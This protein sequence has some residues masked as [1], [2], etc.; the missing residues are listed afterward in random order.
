MLRRCI[1]QNLIDS[2][3][4]N[5]L[6]LALYQA[7]TE[8]SR[9]PDAFHQSRSTLGQRIQSTANMVPFG[10]S[11]GDFA[12]A[13]GL[14]VKISKAL[15]DSGTAAAE[16]RDIIQDLQTLQ[17]LLE[18][19]ETLRPADGSV[20]HINAIRGMALACRTPLLEFAE[21]IESYEPALCVGSSKGMFT[22]GVKKVQWAVLVEEGIAKFRGIIAAK[23][24]IITLLL[25]AFNRYDSYPGLQRK[26]SFCSVMHCQGWKVS[27]VTIRK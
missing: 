5:L 12:T 15:K 24:Q 8:S 17:Q 7:T 9:S 23:V 19:L 16:C 14:I 11:A 25:E 26:C 20:N 10:F 18:F 6:Y 2:R 4:D 1:F 27:T 13:I 22:R 3:F 21:K